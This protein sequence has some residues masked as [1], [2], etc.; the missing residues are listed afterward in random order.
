MEY[1]VRAKVLELIIT[2][3]SRWPKGIL[4]E[5]SL[6]NSILNHPRDGYR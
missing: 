4:K 5:I 2:Q 1:S 6:K 3:Y